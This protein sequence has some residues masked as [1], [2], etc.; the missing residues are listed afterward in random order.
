MDPNVWSALQ[1]QNQMN[2][3]ERMSNTAYQRAVKDLQAAGLNPVL[4]ANT[5]GASTPSGAMG[6]TFDTGIASGV[7][8]AKGVI[9]EVGSVLNE[10]TKEVLKGL[11]TTLTD[12]FDYDDQ[13]YSFAKG[14]F[15]SKYP[16]SGWQKLAN[17]VFDFVDAHGGS[18]TSKDFII[19]II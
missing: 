17:A 2:F 5:S 11:M 7:S 19:L 1:A 18:K 10:N 6:Q 15:Y 8:S 3:Q 14:L 4:A 12:Q 16:K 9:R 13:G